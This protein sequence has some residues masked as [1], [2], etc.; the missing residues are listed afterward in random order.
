MQKLTIRE[1]RARLSHY[2][3]RMKQGES[4]LVNRLIMSAK[5]EQEK[6]QGQTVESITLSSWLA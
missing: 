4:F 5:S 3:H 6:A 1:F 2:M